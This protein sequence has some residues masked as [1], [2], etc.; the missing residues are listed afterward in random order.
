MMMSWTEKERL[1]LQ[2]LKTQEQLC[3]DK[4]S[5]YARRAS[6]PELKALFEQIRTAE[7]HHL[8]A[9]NSLIHG[10][11]PASGQQGGTSLPRFAPVQGKADQQA[12]KYLCQDALCTEK[13]V[14]GTYDTCIFE[15]R[16]PQV[17]DLLSSFQ[18]AEQQHGLQLY[19]YMAGSGMAP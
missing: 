9:I 18:S 7:Q 2:D 19:Q 6:D 4:Y 3:V 14:S 15:F 1:L 8:D 10:Q 17:R 13:E 12:D 11:M 5:E 16:D